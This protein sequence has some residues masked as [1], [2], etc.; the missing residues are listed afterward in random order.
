M[1]EDFVTYEQAK[2]LKELGFDWKC[3]HFYCQPKGKELRLIE[4]IPMDFMD[5]QY[6]NFNNPSTWSD[7]NDNTPSAPT[8]AQVQKWLRETKQIEIN[9][10]YDPI[11]KNGWF[12]YR[13][14]LRVDEMWGGLDHFG[15]GEYFSTY[16][17]A[18]S[19]GISGILKTLNKQ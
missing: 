15:D 16:E 12:Y 19:E 9:S 2:L 3:N 13:N 17:E 5:S 11:T 8:L 18:L 14:D 4:Y 6:H 1:N 10:T 7:N